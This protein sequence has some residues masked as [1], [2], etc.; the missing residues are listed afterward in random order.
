MFF[1][2]IYHILRAALGPGVCTASNRN[3]YQKQKNNNFNFHIC[4]QY[5][6]KCI[7]FY[8]NVLPRHV[9]NNITLQ[10]NKASGTKKKK[11]RE[12]KIY[13]KYIYIYIY[14]YTKRT[15][16]HFNTFYIYYILISYTF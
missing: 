7:L 12:E 6:M 1:F 11:K 4:L 13:N 10:P 2:L 16:L 5:Q 15:I 8:C 3:V 14:I 9:E